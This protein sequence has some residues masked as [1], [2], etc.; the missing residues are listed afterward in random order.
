MTYDEELW[1]EGQDKKASQ[2]HL[3][4]PHNDANE[5]LWF[6]SHSE[7]MPQNPCNEYTACIPRHLLHQ[8]YRLSAVCESI[9]RFYVAANS[10]NKV[11]QPLWAQTTIFKL[12]LCCKV[13]RQAWSF[14]PYSKGPFIENVNRRIWLP[15]L[16]EREELNCSQWAQAEDLIRPWTTSHVFHLCGDD[17]PPDWNHPDLIPCPPL[18]GDSCPSGFNWLLTSF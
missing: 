1:S 9:L 12:I 18:S 15:M 5:F 8:M 17:L 10:V 7:P 6:G 16:R 3:R 4:Q 2:L 11:F 13:R 14:C